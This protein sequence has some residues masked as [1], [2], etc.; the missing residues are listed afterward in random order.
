MSWPVPAGSKPASDSGSQDVKQYAL[1]HIR[2]TM[3]SHLDV[4]IAILRPR[5]WQIAGSEDLKEDD[6]CFI[7]LVERWGLGGE[8]QGACGLLGFTGPKMLLGLEQMFIVHVPFYRVG[9][10]I[11]RCIGEFPCMD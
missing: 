5:M 2:L 8:A 4:P 7:V 3:G 11:Y 10:W 6:E 9:P 1:K